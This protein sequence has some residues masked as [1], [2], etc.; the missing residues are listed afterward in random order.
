MKTHSGKIRFHL[1]HLNSGGA[2][3]CGSHG[4]GP[5]LIHVG[6]A[7]QRPATDWRGPRP[8]GRL[9]GGQRPCLLPPDG[10]LGRGE[11][12]RS[13]DESGRLRPPLAAPDPPERSGDGGAPIPALNGPRRG[14]ERGHHGPWRTAARSGLGARLGWRN[15]K[16]NAREGFTGVEG[17]HRSW[18]GKGRSLAKSGFRRAGAAAMTA[19]GGSGAPGA[20][21]S[22]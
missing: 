15:G 13:G 19:I 3:A 21:V 7:G 20:R 17:L 9:Q 1:I 22:S 14:R 5:S 8:A 12:T 16:G 10:A 4:W 2:D 18:N 6:W 11:A